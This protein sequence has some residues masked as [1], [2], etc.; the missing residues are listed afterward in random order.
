[1]SAASEMIQL[2]L[3]SA[4]RAITL[5]R[6]QRDEA[7]AASLPAVVSQ[8]DRTIS[9]YTRQHQTEQ[10]WQQQ[11]Q[12]S[13]SRDEAG[14]MNKTLD[15]A[16]SI[17]HGVCEAHARQKAKLPRPDAAR[18]L[19]ARLY[20]NGLAAVVKGPY[21]TQ[22]AAMLAIAAAYKE[23]PIQDAAALLGVDEQLQLVVDQTDAFG[24]AIRRAGRA[25]TFRDVTADRA[26]AHAELCELTAAI[27]CHT[28]GDDDA[29]T[30]TRAKLLKP[31][32]TQL[33]ITRAQRAEGRQTDL[34]PNTG[35]EHPV[36]P[37]ADPV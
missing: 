14:A 27:L 2:P 23:Q 6:E 28:Y 17:T 36:S 1:M 24:V 15:E 26:Q 35:D 32:H 13:E 8:C 19:L 16:L 9:A 25:L 33:A 31:L 12:S 5:V 11:Q 21:E 20:P 34:D 37:I 7:E 29:A 10:S 3:V 30:A 22:Y 18:L 4:G